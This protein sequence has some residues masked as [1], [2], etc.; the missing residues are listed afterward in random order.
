M[1]RRTVRDETFKVS[2]T[3]SIVKSLVIGRPRV[4]VPVVRGLAFGA[5]FRANN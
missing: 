1:R 5:G 4:P 3:S 2:A